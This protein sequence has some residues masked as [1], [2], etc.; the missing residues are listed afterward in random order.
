MNVTKR[1]LLTICNNENTFAIIDNA[2][3]LGLQNSV[4]LLKEKE[5]YMWFFKIV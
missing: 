4:N 1:A 5:R 2:L 3:A